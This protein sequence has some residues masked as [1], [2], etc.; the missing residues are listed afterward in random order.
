MPWQGWRDCDGLWDTHLGRLRFVQEDAGRVFGFAEYDAAARIEGEFE[1]TRLTF[2][3]EAGNFSGRGVL[4]LDPTG[5][6]LNGEWLE[7]G[8]PSRALERPAHPAAAGTD[9][10]GRGRGVLAARARRQ[11]VRVRRHAAGAVRAAAARTSA[12]SLLSRRDEPAALV[13]A[14]SVPAGAGGA[15]ARRPWRAQRPH[16]QRQDHPG[17][18]YSRRPAVTPTGCSFCISRPAWS[19]RTASAR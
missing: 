2:T 5:Y 8:Q 7:Q 10:A 13:P 3:L 12:A 9:L 6:M 11:R 18:A 19:G 17:R 1:G 14:A 16:R 4:D 15:D